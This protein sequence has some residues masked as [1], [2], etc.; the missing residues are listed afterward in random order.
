VKIF[1]IIA[2][3][4]GLLLAVR[5]MFFGVQR[6]LDE[7]HLAHRV[8]PLALAAFLVTT[9][10]LIYARE[11]SSAPVTVVWVGVVALVG[12][13]TGAALWWFVRRSAVSPS[14]D[15]D[16]DPK[17]RFQGHVARV[18][19]AIEKRVAGA[20]AGR[21]AFSFDG[22]RYEFRARWVP[23]DWERERLLGAIES[24]VVI[25]RVED[26]VAYVEPWKVVEER[27]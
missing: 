8:W 9:G 22:K 25:E 10:A 14:T 16:D 7:N 3:L 27:L 6:R 15:P 4:G 2:F 13:G 18:T 5:V 26:D 19:E 17:Y 23:G 24:E 21:I 12:L 20:A 1:A 11:A